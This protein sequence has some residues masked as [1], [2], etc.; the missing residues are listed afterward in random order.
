MKNLLVASDLTALSDR[1]VHRAERL[2]A[3]FGANLTVVHVIE[4]GLPAGMRRQLG[5]EAVRVIRDQL[6]VTTSSEEVKGDIRV[7]SGEPFSEIIRTARS[8]DADLIILGMHRK[9]GMKELFAGTTVERVLRYS[10]RPV[11][12]V[13]D[14]ATRDYERVLIPVD[15]SVPSRRALTT[16]CRVVPGGE[17]NVVHAY[18]VPFSGFITDDL[19]RHEVEESRTARLEAMIRE[20]MDALVEKLGGNSR[21]VKHCVQRGAVLEVIYDQIHAI[22]PDLLVMGTHGRTG[23]AHAMVG[24]VA[25]ELI[26][27]P[28]CD[29]LTVG[30]W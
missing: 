3:Q 30:A 13:K 28:P 21:R 9:Q 14:Q 15:F 12:V 22:R 5:D 20:E 25:Q 24:S 7:A 19:A 4:E 23:L 11:L 17:Y 27:E 1:A 29:V 10:D 8:V 2:A 16:A 26:V 6:A 18:H